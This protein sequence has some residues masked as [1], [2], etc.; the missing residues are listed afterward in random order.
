MG[1]NVDWISLSGIYGFSFQIEMKCV[2]FVRRLSSAKQQAR[3]RE[4]KDE[5]VIS[6][7]IAAF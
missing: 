3:K 2:S 4:Q 5:E 7:F 1:T 6:R